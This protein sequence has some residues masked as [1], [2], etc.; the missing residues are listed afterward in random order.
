MSS[1]LKL[2]WSFLTRSRE[3]LELLDEER[4]TEQIQIDE[5]KKHRTM[6]G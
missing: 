4:G 5:V 1:F 3:W 6:W 2:M